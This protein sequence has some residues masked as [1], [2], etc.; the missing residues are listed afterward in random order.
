MSLFV[1]TSAIY[2]GLDADDREHGR[3]V[4]IWKSLIQSGELIS[5][6]NYVLVEVTALIQNRIGIEAVQKFQEDFLPLF[7]IIWIDDSL[8]R[9]GMA[10]LLTA[11][12]KNL[13]LVDCVS[14]E[15][16]RRLDIKSVFTFDYHF[17]EQGFACLPQ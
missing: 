15:V 11:R 5:T 7:E 8:H 3:A 13:S 4:K 1:D 9:S 6:T 16:M 12:R 10:A 2:A 17:K 14:F